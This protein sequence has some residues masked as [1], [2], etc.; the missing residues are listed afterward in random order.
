M[1]LILNSSKTC[2]KE[3]LYPGA[4]LAIKKK[5]PEEELR[6]TVKDLMEIA[7]MPKKDFIEDL[8]Q[9]LED[10]KYLIDMGKEEAREYLDNTEI[11]LK[12]VNS[13]CPILGEQ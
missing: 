11:L 1:N 5:I 13:L 9:K 8:Q 6:I 2:V 7:E 12:V 3:M 10:L 4:L